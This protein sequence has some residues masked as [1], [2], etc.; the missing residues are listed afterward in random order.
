[1]SLGQSDSLCQ[2]RSGEGLRSQTVAG[3]EEGRV[4][5][6]GSRLGPGEEIGGRVWGRFLRSSLDETGFSSEQGFL[7]LTVLT[8]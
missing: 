1:M 5:L 3:Q 2:T 6:C 4:T 7:F 8:D